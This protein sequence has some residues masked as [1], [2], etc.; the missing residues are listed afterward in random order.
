[1]SGALTRSIF[2]GP[3]ALKATK[4]YGDRL[5]APALLV[6][7]CL[8]LGVWGEPLLAVARMSVEW[9]LNPDLYITVVLGG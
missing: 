3:R 9:M 5:I 8:V 6:G 1:M 7:L 4:P 2:W